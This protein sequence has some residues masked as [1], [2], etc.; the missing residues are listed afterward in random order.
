VTSRLRIFTA[1]SCA[2]AALAIASCSQPP[3]VTQ[4]ASRPAADLGLVQV[5]PPTTGCDF[6]ELHFDVY[7]H[8]HVAG[9][10]TSA[11]MFD[12]QEVRAD[13][14][15]PSAIVTQ[16][17]VE[18]APDGGRA[19][20]RARLEGLTPCGT[21]IVHVRVMTDAGPLAEAFYVETACMT[22]PP[23]PMD[24][25][26]D[27]HDATVADADSST[28]ITSIDAPDSETASPDASE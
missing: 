24:A 6:I 8:D 26:I 21:Y 3:V 15:I 22:F 20:Y 12:V 4:D 7:D 19:F 10:P 14:A 17:G 27:V 28:D 23:C 25:G 16:G 2:A 5:D 9:L 1:A 18:V 11:F 13:A